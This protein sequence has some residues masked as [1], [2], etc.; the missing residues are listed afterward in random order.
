MPSGRG[1]V[2]VGGASFQT[3]TCEMPRHISHYGVKRCTLQ[4]V[5]WELKQRHIG[6]DLWGNVEVLAHIRRKS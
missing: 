1:V 5:D 4:G 6:Y 3:P 2:A